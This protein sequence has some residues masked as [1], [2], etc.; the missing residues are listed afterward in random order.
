MVLESDSPLII[1]LY[2][3]QSKYAKTRRSNKLKPNNA[4]EIYMT[5]ISL[6]A[7]IFW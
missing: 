1:L 7:T 5:K 2:C 4:A 6:L 3:F